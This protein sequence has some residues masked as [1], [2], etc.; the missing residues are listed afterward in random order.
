MGWNTKD[1][2]RLKKENK[3]RGYSLPTGKPR[4]EPRGKIV[5]KH[6]KRSDDKKDWIASNLLYWCNSQVVQLTEEYLFDETRERRFKFDW[7]IVS[8]KI[9][10]EYEGGLLNPRSGHRSVTGINR[11]VT[12]YNLATM[13]GWRVLRFTSENYKTLLQALK[14]FEQ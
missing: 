1:L 7:A 4:Q 3:I 10:I 12:K 13:Q 2:E 8:L 6:F 11:D 9:A 14:K 5:A